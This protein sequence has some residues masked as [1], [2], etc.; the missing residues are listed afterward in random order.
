MFGDFDYDWG[1][2]DWYESLLIDR[3]PP[4]RDERQ[5]FVWELQHER[6]PTFYPDALAQV[7]WGPVDVPL[8]LSAYVRTMWAEGAACYIDGYF[9]ATVTVIPAALEAALK[10]EIFLKQ[11]DL[12]LREM[13]LGSCIFNSKALGILVEYSDSQRDE[14][15]KAGRTP[16]QEQFATV[17]ARQVNRYRVG[18]IHANK[19][20]SEP[21]ESF[22]IDD[23]TDVV[24]GEWIDDG[25]PEGAMNV[26]GFRRYEAAAKNVLR[27]TAVVLDYL[28]PHPA[29]EA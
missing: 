2:V 1:G 8:A 4:K 5:K 3:K 9:M 10:R 21:G 25:T 7:H 24:L 26:A 17:A 27:D 23:S 22:Q 12:A 14:D 16:S 29:A 18:L 15:E 19:E 6:R 28:Y 11:P 20:R 13:G